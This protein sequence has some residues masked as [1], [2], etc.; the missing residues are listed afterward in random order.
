MIMKVHIY[1]VI[2]GKGSRAEQSN[3]QL[4]RLFSK[5]ETNARQ[6]LKN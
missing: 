1:K 5:M 4:S 3:L 2:I 6:K